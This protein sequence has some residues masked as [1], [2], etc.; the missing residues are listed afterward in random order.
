MCFCVTGL[1]N[2]NSNNYGHF[3]T[4]FSQPTS[5]QNTAAFLRPVVQHSNKD[6]PST[7][8]FDLPHRSFVLIVYAL[9]RHKSR[10]RKPQE[11]EVP[12]VQL[13]Y[14]KTEHES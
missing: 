1:A 4:M 10:F 2:L 6:G 3:P 11:S 13:F 14:L 7:R 5:A 9:L 12:T 8:L